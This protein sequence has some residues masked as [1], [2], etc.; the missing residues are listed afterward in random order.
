MLEWLSLRKSS[1]S[2]LEGFMPDSGRIIQT[3]IFAFSNNGEGIRLSW[4]GNNV[5]TQGYDYQAYVQ[6]ATLLPIP[7]Q[8]FFGLAKEDWPFDWGGREKSYFDSIGRA[9]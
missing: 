9:S 8:G 2:L 5:A 1:E 4:W 3:L 6:N 7:E